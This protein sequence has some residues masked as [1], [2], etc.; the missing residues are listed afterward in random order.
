MML[1]Y[2]VGAV[3]AGRIDFGDGTGERK[4]FLV[5]LNDCL[6]G[7][8]FFAALTTSKHKY[9][10]TPSP[11]G[12]PNAPCYRIEAGQVDC[13]PVRTWIQ[14]DNANYLTPVRLQHL[15]QERRATFVQMLDDDKIRSVLACAKKSVDIPR[16]VLARIDRTLKAK[17][18]ERKT[19]SKRATIAAEPSASLF[20]MANQEMLT[21][22]TRFH[23]HCANCRSQFASLIG[24]AE[25]ELATI[26]HGSK[27]PP[28]D[29]VSNAEVGFALIAGT[30][31]VCAT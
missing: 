6:E 23:R 8:E 15:A 29:F 17:L 28:A 22:S 13:F 26:F 1:G 18:T 31:V 30:C 16:R 19:P 25:A 24:I 12:C 11:C 14:F 27:Q 3:W 5:L 2:R 4:K 20:G 21:V 10:E 9:G 7:E